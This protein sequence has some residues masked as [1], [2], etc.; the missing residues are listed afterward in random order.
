LYRSGD[1]ARM[2]PDGNIECLGRVDHQLKIRG[3]R[4]ELG[5][6]EAA[7]LQ[8]SSVPCAVVVAREDSPGNKRLVAYVT[9][10]APARARATASI[11]ASLRQSLPEHMVPAAIVVLD[12]LPLTP[13]GK[14][15]RAALPAPARLT[16]IDA[17]RDALQ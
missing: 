12:S 5:E 13:N 15:D 1:V 17:P 6:I 2:R 10:A 3:Y 8:Q 4:V 7:I 9:P 16:P 14:V 11:L